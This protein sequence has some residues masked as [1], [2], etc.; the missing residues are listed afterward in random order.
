M[1]MFVS[2]EQNHMNHYITNAIYFQV[3]CT[4]TTNE[5]KETMVSLC[6][7]L[8]MYLCLLQNRYVGIFL[9]ILYNTN[10][11]HITTI[12]VQECRKRANNAHTHTLSVCSSKF[13]MV[14]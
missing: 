13:Q 14:W 5:K 3:K 4:M 6:N 8:K 1:C 11:F 9:L 12:V 7:Q 10:A 2:T